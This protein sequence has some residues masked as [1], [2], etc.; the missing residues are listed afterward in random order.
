MA[1]NGNT[2]RDLFTQIG[3]L[4][5]DTAPV[6]LMWKD[7]DKMSTAERLKYVDAAI[8]DMQQ[9]VTELWTLVES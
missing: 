1:D 4:M 7:S 9:L 8:C 6:A 5:E 2:I 3:I